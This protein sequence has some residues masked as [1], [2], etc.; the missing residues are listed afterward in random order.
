MFAPVP[1][2][3]HPPFS[4][5][6]ATTTYTLVCDVGT[7]T[8]S[9]QNAGLLA[10][11]VL[12]CD[13]GLF[14]LTGQAATFTYTPRTTVVIDTHDGFV[15][16]D[17]EAKKKERLRYMLQHA[18]DPEAFP[19]PIPEPAVIELAEPFMERAESGR[20][21]LDWKAIEREA[22]VRAQLYAMAE[23]YERQRIAFEEDE[24]DVATLLLH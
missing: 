3:P 21:E 22:V 2:S 9:G 4:T 17:T 11:R 14:S 10:N 15:E 24:E 20:V 16:D 8:L 18:V 7:F 13:V 23:E 12:V 1:F 6:R 5:H 19:W